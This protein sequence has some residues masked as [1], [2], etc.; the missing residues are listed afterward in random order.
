[1]PRKEEEAT[2][3]R[4]MAFL[5]EKFDLTPV[6]ARIV[7]RLVAEDT[8]RLS[9]AAGGLAYETARTTLKSVFRKTSTCRQAQLVMMIIRAGLPPPARLTTN[10]RHE[11]G[12]ATGRGR[13]AAAAM[14][15]A[16]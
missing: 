2:S 16:V 14:K 9:A 13:W 1:M 5:K 8:L 12:G 10:I 4:P 11:P 6:E 3:F 7:L 15:V